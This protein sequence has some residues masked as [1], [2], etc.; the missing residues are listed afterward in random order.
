VDAVA[1]TR[2]RVVLR[3]GRVDEEALLAA[4]ASGVMSVRP[5]TLHVIVGLDAEDA[6]RDMRTLLAR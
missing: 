4:G 3:D 1:A 6:A 2:L 5:D